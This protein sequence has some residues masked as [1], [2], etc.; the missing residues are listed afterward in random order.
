MPRYSVT[1]PT[2]PEGEYSIHV[3]AADPTEAASVAAEEDL[4]TSEG[5]SLAY[6]Y[7]PEVWI[8]RHPY[9]YGWRSRHVQGPNYGDL[10]GEGMPFV[11]VPVTT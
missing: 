2:R 1:W 7:E 9:R 3:Y 10:A 6:D 5:Y 11:P 4:P 8:L